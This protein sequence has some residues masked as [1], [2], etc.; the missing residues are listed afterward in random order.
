MTAMDYHR[1]SQGERYQSALHFFDRDAGVP[2]P[3][4]IRLNSRLR[5]VQQ[6]LCSQTR[7]DD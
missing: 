7:D 3:A 1:L 5:S 6:L 2:A 4:L